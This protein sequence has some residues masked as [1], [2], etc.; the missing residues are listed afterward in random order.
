MKRFACPLVKVSPANSL[1]TVIAPSRL[2][3][4]KNRESRPLSVAQRTPC[5]SCESWASGSSVS[6]FHRSRVNSRLAG[7]PLAIDPEAGTR[8]TQLVAET[9]E[10]R[11]NL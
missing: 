4:L 9:A 3:I 7:P 6:R 2:A 10:L 1:G 11:L 5:E 8:G